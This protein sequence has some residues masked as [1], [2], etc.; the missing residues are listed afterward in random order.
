LFRLLKHVLHKRLESDQ[1][2]S[3]LCLLFIP[4]LEVLQRKCDQ[5]ISES[6]FV[7]LILIYFYRV[8]I[9]VSIYCVLDWLLLTFVHSLG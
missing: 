6:D 3:H 7:G 1:F 2:L 4:F 5:F 9:D 8:T